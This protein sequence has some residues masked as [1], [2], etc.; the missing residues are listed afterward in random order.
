MNYFSIYVVFIW[1]HSLEFY[2]YSHTN[3]I[4]IFFRFISE[5]L[6]SG[7]C[8]LYGVVFLVYVLLAHLFLVCKKVID[9][10]MLA[11]ILQTYYN[12]FKF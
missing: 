12:H 11:C 6:I 2:S 7:D 10:Y 9:F 4:Y 8:N 5:Y 3:L 1:I